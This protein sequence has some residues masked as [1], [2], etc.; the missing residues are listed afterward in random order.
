NGS[1]PSYIL[2]FHNN[3]CAWW[4]KVIMKGPLPES[5]TELEY[6]KRGSTFRK[7]IEAINFTRLQLLDNTYFVKP[8]FDLFKN[9]YVA[10]AH[11]MHCNIMEDPGRVISLTID[12]RHLHVQD[13]RTFDASCLQKTKF[14]APTV[15]T[16]TFE[17]QKFAYKTIDPS[18]YEPGD[19][20]NILYEIDALSQL[21]GHSDI[22]Q[23]LGV[24]VS[25]NPY[26]TNPSNEISIV[27]TGFLLEY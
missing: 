2:V 21:R 13:L 11:K 25:E 23:L 8:C 22:A 7:F 5:I 17:Q 12:Q 18:V 15:S 19:T 3:G 10:V 4:V 14:V 6:L 9:F 1:W 20:Q 27:I 26:K 24:V 16:V